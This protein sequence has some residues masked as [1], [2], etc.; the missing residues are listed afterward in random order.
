MSDGEARQVDDPS[1]ATA[2]RKPH[3]HH[4]GIPMHRLLTVE[5]TP[6]LVELRRSTR[7]PLTAPVFFSW[8][9]RDGIMHDHSGTTRNVSMAGAFIAADISPLPGAP[10]GVDIYLPVDVSGRTVE[11]HGEGKVARVDGPGL[12]GS[13]FAAEVMFQTRSAGDFDGTGPNEAQ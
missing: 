7:F 6:Q 9:D 8:V 5:S 1:L 11:L 2:L 13:G 4:L 12:T 10:I 3:S